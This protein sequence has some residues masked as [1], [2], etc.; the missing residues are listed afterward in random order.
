MELELKRH[1]WRSLQGVSGDAGALESALRALAQAGDR[2]EAVQAA[3]RVERVIFAQGLLC[4]AS[5]AAASTLVHCLWR[6][7]EHAEDLILGM[8][9]DISVAVVD[10]EDP[11]VYGPTSQEQCLSEIRLG[12]PMYVEIL[13]AGKSIHSRTACIDLILACGLSDERLRGRSVY[14]LGKALQ[15]DGLEG[16]R[17]VIH[18]SIREL[19]EGGATR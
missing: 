18:A 12:F 7:S 17:D 14:F 6:R 19:S 4:E 3:R 15:L 1:E 13:E 2:D 5:A 11:T 16:H 9:S 8:L 10:E